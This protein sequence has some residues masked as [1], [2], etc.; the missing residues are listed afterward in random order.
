MR[1]IVPL[2]ST[3]AASRHG[4]L[5]PVE[6]NQL[7]IK[8]ASVMFSFPV[9]SASPRM[10]VTSLL[11]G[12]PPTE[13]EAFQFSARSLSRVAESSVSSRLCPGRPTNFEG[14]RAEEHPKFARDMRRSAGPS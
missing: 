10:K 12:V 11:P 2:S 6:N 14:Q 8:S 7:M 1:L 13:S 4:G 3:S 5:P 9:L